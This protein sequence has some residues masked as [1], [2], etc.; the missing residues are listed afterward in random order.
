MKYLLFIYIL[1]CGCARLEFEFADKTTPIITE[2]IKSEYKIRTRIAIKKNE[3]D[4]ITENLDQILN[5]FS[6]AEKIYSHI[7]LKFI[8]T[9]CDFVE[10]ISIDECHKD[11]EK[12]PNMMSVYFLDTTRE[13]QGEAAYPFTKL[14]QFG[15]VMMK[16][17]MSECAL[18]HEIGHYFG[19]MH[20][21]ERDDFCSD[22]QS[23]ILIGSACSGMSAN[24]GNVM[25]YCFHEHRFA[26]KEQCK[27][28]LAFLITTRKSHIID[29]YEP[30]I[31]LQEIFK[32]FFQPP[33]KEYYVE[34]TLNPN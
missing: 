5:E 22:T 23:E 2:T 33:F 28:F 17:R 3:L 8:I 30:F 25:N 16:S 11:A 21:F 20:T 34:H 12:Y 13:F 29:G 1:F 32:P 9:K 7:N 18:A 10:K 4:A 31:D 24:C 14:E 26:T 6:F 27:R 15:I 19:L